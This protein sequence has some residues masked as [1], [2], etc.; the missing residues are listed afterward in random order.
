MRLVRRAVFSV[1]VVLALATGCFASK[2]TREGA[3]RLEDALGT[4]SWAQS[5]D[6]ETRVSG[7]SD[8]VVETVVVLKDDADADEVADFVLDHPD[9]VS[10]AG[11]GLGFA[12]LRFETS[13]GAVL[14]V[15]FADP[16][17]DD[18]VR[19]AVRRWLAVVPLL[20]P[21]PTAELARPTGGSSYVASLAEGGGP[22]VADLF[23]QLRSSDELAAPADAWSVSTTEGGL[24]MSLASHTLPTEDDVT[25]W[26]A[27]VDALALLPARFEATG[28]S[29][30]RYD[31]HAGVDLMLLMPDDVTRENLTPA[32]YGDELWPALQAQLR[33]VA[34]LRG[35]WSYLVQWAPADV[36][37]W[38][39]IL[40]S[41][42]DDQEP[43]D[44]HDP[45]SQWSA[46]ARDYVDRL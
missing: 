25:G 38:T 32:G 34:S 19:A 24:T 22:A 33:A 7:L 43:I 44:N 23:D 11:L 4:P 16:T 18:A 5:V 27:L 20:G 26:L 39:T 40:L 1:V 31:P 29:L 36:P 35:G 21:S 37:D 28:I 9:R 2:E 13:D 17:D 14:T 30:Q 8:D 42:L 45:A 15:P 46:E 10:D 12:D 3:G 6:V 41:L